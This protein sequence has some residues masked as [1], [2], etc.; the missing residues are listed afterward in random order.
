MF[1]GMIAGPSLD[2]KRKQAI[3]SHLRQL[4]G[5]S[6]VCGAIAHKHIQDFHVFVDSDSPHF[7]SESLPRQAVTYFWGGYYLQHSLKKGASTFP[8]DPFQD[9]GSGEFIALKLESS[10]SKRVT[11]EGERSVRL[12]SVWNGFSGSWP[13]Y[14]GEHNGFCAAS[15]D[16]LFVAV[17]LRL[18]D[19][20]ER[21]VLEML[22]FGHSINGRETTISGVRRLAANHFLRISPSGTSSTYQLQELEREHR[23]EYKTSSASIPSIK[24]VFRS[25]QTGVA[26]LAPLFDGA[27]STSIQLSAGLDSRLTAY[28]VSKRSIPNQTAITVK[29]EGIREVEVASQVANRL[30]IAHRTL[31]LKSS[32]LDPQHSQELDTLETESW[33]LTGGQVS[34][35]AAMP[36]VE[37]MREVDT[38]TSSLIIGGWPGDCLIGSYVPNTGLV[39]LELMNAISIRRWSRGRLRP[40][41][42]LG[43]S[44]SSPAELVL[45]EKESVSK[46]SSLIRKLPG[47]TAAHKISFWSMFC[48]QPAFSYVAPSVLSS[49]HLQVTPLL[50]RPYIDHLLKLRALDL[51]GKSFYRKLIYRYLV[52][53]RDVPYDLKF[54]TISTEQSSPGLVPKS[55]EAFLFLV[56]EGLLRLGAGIRKSLSQY[57]RRSDSAAPVME[58][59]AILTNRWHG[60]VTSVRFKESGMEITAAG[61]S[62][63]AFGSLEAVRRTQDYLTAVL[64]DAG[65]EGDKHR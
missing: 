18:S 48:R 9:T 63:H 47:K 3:D 2:P 56:P 50:W 27:G 52:E 58:E 25:L 57:L 7:S 35:A 12:A 19:L 36:N 45:F 14:F 4:E 54:E 17:A 15:N 23:L 34:L 10:A 11:K 65:R 53:L 20:S 62:V 13:V 21:G 37:F 40:T 61:T 44:C 1:F 26:R 28:L 8:S 22:Y 42:S 32:A 16:P 33:L 29:L 31:Q 24:E 64:G 38:G 46:L 60:R 30:G 59:Q 39:Q 43:I 49:N 55:R 51:M 41:E 5:T 6:F